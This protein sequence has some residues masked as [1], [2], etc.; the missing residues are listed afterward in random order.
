MGRDDYPVVRTLGL[1]FPLVS[2][3]LFIAVQNKGFKKN[4]KKDKT[5]FPIPQPF[6][7]SILGFIKI[8]ASKKA[9]KT[10]PELD[11]GFAQD[12]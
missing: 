11:F 6:Q 2:I 10:L 1:F 7:V 12:L 3:Q 8:L 9:F 4:T 5:N